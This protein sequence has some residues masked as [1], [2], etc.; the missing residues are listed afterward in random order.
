MS[1]FIDTWG[2][3]VLED[4]LDP[5]HERTVK[6]YEK[7]W[8][9]Q[10]TVW[11]SDFVL[12][13]TLTFLFMRRP[14]AEA[15]R[16]ARGI[17]ASPSIRIESVTR[18]RFQ[19][20]FGLRERFSDKPKISFTDLTSMAIMSELKITNVVTADAHFAHVGLGFQRLPDS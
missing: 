9:E 3:I 13:E 1:T 6:C 15:R 11:T 20:A 17:L 4:R 14:F 10:G 2:W 19:A 5:S 18:Q 7:A 12:D 16:F 8:K